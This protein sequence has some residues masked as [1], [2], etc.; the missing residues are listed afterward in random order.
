MWLGDSEGRI[1]EH[2]EGIITSKSV[3]TRYHGIDGLLRTGIC[4]QVARAGA[5]SLT[6]LTS[7]AESS[8]SKQARRRKRVC[9]HTRGRARS[10]HTRTQ[11]HT[12]VR[13]RGFQIQHELIL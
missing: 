10:D 12:R 3:R 8:G 7:G 6:L 13:A 9:F 4:Y 11:I 2:P 5:P 1:Q